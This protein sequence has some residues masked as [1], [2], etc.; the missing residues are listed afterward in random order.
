MIIVVHRKYAILQLYR[1]G[2][3]QPLFFSIK[4]YS[5]VISRIA[6]YNIYRHRGIYNNKPTGELFILNVIAYTTREV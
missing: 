1:A 4:S 2:R 3:I 5:I 6:V